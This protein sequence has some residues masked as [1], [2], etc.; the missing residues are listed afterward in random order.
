MSHASADTPHPP[1]YLG[2]AQQQL[3]MNPLL[4]PVLLLLLLLALALVGILALGGR[5]QGLHVAYAAGFCSF[6]RGCV[7]LQ[8][9]LLH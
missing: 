6:G 7:P 4:L 1:G 9:L 5:L 2:Q 8:Q 3:Q